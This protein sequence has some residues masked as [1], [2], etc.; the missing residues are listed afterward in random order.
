MSAKETHLFLIQS[1]ENGRVFNLMYILMMLFFT[2]GIGSY[3]ISKDERSS[4]W[5]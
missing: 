3:F 2:L 5:Q 1:S 4:E